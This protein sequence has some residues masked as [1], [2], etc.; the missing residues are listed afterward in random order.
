MTPRFDAKRRW[1]TAAQAGTR[2]PC[3]MMRWCSV[4]VQA[5]GHL[6]WE[7]GY[8]SVHS[9]ITKTQLGEVWKGQGEGRERE[10]GK[11]GCRHDL[12][13]T[14]NPYADVNSFNKTPTIP[15]PPLPLPHPPT[16]THPLRLSTCHCIIFFGAGGSGVCGRKK[17]RNDSPFAYQTHFAVAMPKSLKGTWPPTPMHPPLAL[18]FKRASGGSVVFLVPLRRCFF[19]ATRKERGGVLGGRRVG[20]MEVVRREN[21]ERDGGYEEVKATH[22]RGRPRDGTSEHGC[23]GGQGLW[24]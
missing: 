18:P 9:N 22:Q 3:E 6:P 10:K 21:D 23:R 14:K 19:G 11:G 16:R 17:K 1:A 5:N 7:K 13:D 2:D 12:D 24:W 4:M 20:S 8:D 15:P